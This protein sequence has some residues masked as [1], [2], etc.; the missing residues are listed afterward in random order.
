M[1]SSGKQAGSKPSPGSIEH[2]SGCL[3]AGA[4]GDALGAPVEFSSLRQIRTRFGAGGIRDFVP[5][6]GRIGAITDDT[7]MTMFT[8]EGLIR[9]DN[10]LQQKGICHPPSVI[11]HAYL[12]WL[13]TQ[14][15]RPRHLDKA[16]N[17]GWLMKIPALHS[18]RAPGN[19]C[20]SALRSGEMGTVERP[21]NDSK[22]CGG[23]MRVAPVGLVAAE[24]F[25]MGCELAAITHGHPSGYLSAGFFASVIS[26]ITK[27]NSLESAVAGAR[28]TLLTWPKHEECLNAVD[29][30]LRLARTTPPTPENLELLGGGW[31]GDEAL[32][33]ALYCAIAA[34]DLESG[35][36]MAVNHGGDSDSTGSMVGNIL[37]ALYGKSAIPARWL[38]QLELRGE[39][40]ELASDLYRHFRNDSSSS[41]MERDGDK[42]SGW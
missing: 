35:V 26:S 31:V 3:L 6:Y 27:G 13:E 8:A 25:K 30:A 15:E 42:Y 11:H 34:S 24:P 7:Q 21:I 16:V 28:D 36:I 37:G 12:R 41:S 17:D 22:G 39:I 2:F 4:V 10:R 1:A 20:L 32:A 9:A 5:A 14:G 29:S 33:I 38:A 23:V 18:R 19:T 40:E